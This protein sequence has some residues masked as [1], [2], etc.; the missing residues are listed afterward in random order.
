[1]RRNRFKSNDL[2]GSGRE[3]RHRNR[4]QQRDLRGRLRNRDVAEGT[5]LAMLLVG[6]V[7]VPVP[8]GLR[9]EQADANN[10]RDGHQPR[11][12]TVYGFGFAAFH[13]QR[14]RGLTPAARLRRVRPFRTAPDSQKIPRPVAKSA[15][16]RSQ[17]RTVSAYPNQ[18]QSKA[19]PEA[20][21]DRPPKRS[22]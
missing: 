17:S 7:P 4:S 11:G 12:A 14:L 1:M 16:P 18:F 10:Q 15:R 20:A 6:F 2:L 3:A 19:Q 13:F 5:D 9:G 8:G 22:S 21:Q